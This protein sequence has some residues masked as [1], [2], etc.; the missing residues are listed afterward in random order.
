MDNDYERRPR[1]TNCVLFGNGGSNTIF[2]DNN[3]STTASYNL[4]RPVGDRL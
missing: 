4:L 1:L 2:N 3:S